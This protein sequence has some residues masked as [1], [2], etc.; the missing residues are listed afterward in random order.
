MEKIGPLEG[1]FNFKA[2]HLRGKHG[3]SEPLGCSTIC[4]GVPRERKMEKVSHLVVRQ[5]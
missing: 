2:Y 3:K 4:E 5:F 1:S